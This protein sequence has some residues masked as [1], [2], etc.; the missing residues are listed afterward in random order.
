VRRRPTPRYGLL[1]L[2]DRRCASARQGD[3]F[4]ARKGEC[5]I[6][7][8]DPTQPT[9][10]TRPR[11]QKPFKVWVTPDERTAIEE[12]AAATHLSASAYLRTLGLGYQPKSLLD[13]QHVL[14]LLKLGGDMGRLGGLLK[15]WLVDTPGRGAPVADVQEVLREVMALRR[16]IG[17]KVMTLS[18]SKIHGH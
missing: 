8:D 3:R 15:L 10:N 7:D 4:R 18:P 1:S 13:S 6:V 16:E 14:E 11:G 5:D 17:D 9:I 2:R 12:N